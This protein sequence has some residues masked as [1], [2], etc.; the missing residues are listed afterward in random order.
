M[1]TVG[2]LAMG[3]AHHQG[4]QAEVEKDSPTSGASAH[5]SFS[6]ASTSAFGDVLGYMCTAES[7]RLHLRVCVLKFT[8]AD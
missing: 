4:L 7:A 6:M 1:P 2:S 8:V 3:G 5:G